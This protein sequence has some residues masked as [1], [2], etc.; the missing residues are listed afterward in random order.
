M[1]VGEYVIFAGYKVSN[2]GVHPIADRAEAIRNYPTPTNTKELKG[3]LGLANQMV[4]FERDL[5]HSVN[6]I[7]TELLNG[8]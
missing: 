6:P 5:I 3:F 4:I 1:Q 7:P 8:R 2:E